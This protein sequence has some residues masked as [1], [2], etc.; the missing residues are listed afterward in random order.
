M[1]LVLAPVMFPIAAGYAMLC[2]FHRQV[3]R[4]MP[5]IVSM[6]GENTITLVVTPNTEK[7][8][9]TFDVLDGNNKLQFSFVGSR[10]SKGMFNF[11]QY[12]SDTGELVPIGS[13]S[14]GIWSTFDIFRPTFPDTL[15]ELTSMAIGSNNVKHQSDA[16]D[17]YR[18]VELSDGNVYQWSKRGKV[19]ER[20][21]NLGQ[22]DSEVRERVATVGI[23]QG[24]KGYRITL[25]ENKVSTSVALM[26]SMISYLDQWNTILG[27]G[28][29]Y[30]PLKHGELPWRRV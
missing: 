24:N 2:H 1:E 26:T 10:L 21:Y 30:F 13:V 4:Y 18:V 17:N 6:E 15:D 5:S 25:D 7:G 16:L 19:L 14:I 29:I 3:S 9:S 22:K 23:L 12:D 27:V 20:V 11:N 28:G 8:S